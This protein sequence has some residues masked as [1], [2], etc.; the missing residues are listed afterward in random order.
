MENFLGVSYNFNLLCGV[1]SSQK[2]PVIIVLDQI[3]C[4]SNLKTK[5]GVASEEEISVRFENKLCSYSLP[6]V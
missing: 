3:T 4:L 2:A 5:A 1:S 6:T